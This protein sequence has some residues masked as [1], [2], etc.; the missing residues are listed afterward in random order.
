MKRTGASTRYIRVTVSVSSKTFPD[1]YAHL[2]PLTADMRKAEVLRLMLFR[3][4]D[5]HQ[6][7]AH[8]PTPAHAPSPQPPDKPAD[9]TDPM[10][11]DKLVGD[12]GGGS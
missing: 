11:W 4:R 10:D 9:G 8:A 2:A 7:A 12:F 3:L 5:E 1:G 6:M